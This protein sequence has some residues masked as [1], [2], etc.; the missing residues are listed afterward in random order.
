MKK[1][2]IILLTISLFL[3]SCSLFLLDDELE[4]VVNE[5]NVEYNEPTEEDNEPTEED[6][7]PTVEDNEPREEY[8]EPIIFL[9]KHD[10]SVWER[11]NRWVPDQIIYM[12]ILRN[13]NKIA[14]IWSPSETNENCYIKEFYSELY[15]VVAVDDKE[16][17][18]RITGNRES[19][20][21]AQYN[22]YISNDTLSENKDFFLPPDAYIE[23]NTWVKS[24]VNVDDLNL[25]D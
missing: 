25:C 15:T 5:S 20:Y 2:I 1:P 13:P 7:E 21:A 9:E 24:K 17:S 19:G 4:E 6:N 8:N 3:T 11:T 12:R 16:N 22:F 14:E 18:F 10:M 23:Y